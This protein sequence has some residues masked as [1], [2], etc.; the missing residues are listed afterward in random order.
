MY[1]VSFHMDTSLRFGHIFG[2]AITMH[3]AACG[4]FT[5]RD[6]SEWK[7]CLS[8]YYC[9]HGDA[10][11]VVSPYLLHSADGSIDVAKIAPTSREIEVL[12]CCYAGG[13]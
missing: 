13:T 1:D 11:E 6:P 3:A 4:R 12:P 7:A 9:L 5:L 2:K 10:A 8:M